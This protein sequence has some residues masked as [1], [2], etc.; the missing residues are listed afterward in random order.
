[1]ISDWSGISFEYAFTH[2]K[3]VIFIDVPKKKNNVDLNKFSTEPIEVNIRKQIGEVVLPN[4]VDKIPKLLEKFVADKKNYE[5][6]IRSVCKNTVYNIGTSSEIGTKYILE[7]LENE[8][9]EN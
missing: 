6:Q 9:I 2:E 4:E 3:P 7:L 8:K 1:L 5:N